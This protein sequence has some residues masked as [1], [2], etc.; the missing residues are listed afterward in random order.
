MTLVLLFFWLVL[1]AAVLSPFET[2]GWWAGWG[3]RPLRRQVEQ[4]T[5]YQ[6]EQ[7]PYYLVY[8]TGVAGF[9]GDFL[10]RREH[11]L[12]KRLG[13]QIPGLEIVAD[14]F[15]FSVNNNPL[16]GDR[17]LR[18]LWS[19]LHRLRLH[20]PNNVFDVLIVVRNIF[21]F[22]VSADRR[23]GPLY[24]LG[25]AREV[26]RRLRQRGY[27]PG[28]GQM[29]SVLAY[30]GG[31][32]IA[33]GMAPYLQAEL[34]C[35]LQVVSLGGVY[36]DDEGIEAV[37]RVIDFRGHRDRWVPDLGRLLFPGRWRWLYFSAWNRARSKIAFRQ[38]GNSTHVGSQDYFSRT[39]A[40]ATCE[41]VV[42]AIFSANRRKGS[43]GSLRQDGTS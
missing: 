18:V 1:A 31:A 37:E 17:I 19:W 8:F 24:N 27:R 7:A 20:L 42:E 21:Q 10:A 13:D 41:R 3:E 2:L 5:R 36:S 25:V 32:Q 9:S 14:V 33:V 30:S 40:P 4:A 43:D 16:D 22:L 38:A 6:G 35:R 34:G 39:Q 28:S 29:I 12:L 15:P 26:S 23:Y 11:G